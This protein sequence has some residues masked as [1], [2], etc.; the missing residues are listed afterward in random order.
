[1]NS[2]WFEYSINRLVYLKYDPVIQFDNQFLC[3]KTIKPNKK[4][5]KSS[6]LNT[7]KMRR[8]FLRKNRF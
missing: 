7:Q 1:M 6:K 4:I 3:L 2:R 8:N 5:R